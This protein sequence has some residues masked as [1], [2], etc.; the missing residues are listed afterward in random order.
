VS[1]PTD[2]LEVLR[3]ASGPMRTGEIR[4]ALGLEGSEGTTKVSGALNTLVQRGA[5]ERIVDEGGYTYVAVPGWEP[6]KRGGGVPSVKGNTR[7]AR[8]AAGEKPAEKARAQPD[9]KPHRQAAV[10]PPVGNPPDLPPPSD[11]PAAA[12]AE[13]EWPFETVMLSRRAVRVLV[14]AAMG[15]DGPLPPDLRRAVIEATEASA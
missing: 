4:D 8:K 2:V 1:V 13:P 15:Q 6:A 14:A 3:N 10:A 9:M 11:P 5:V 12:A 7:A